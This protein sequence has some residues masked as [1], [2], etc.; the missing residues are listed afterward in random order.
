MSGHKIVALWFVLQIVL[1]FTAP[2]QTCDLRDLF[3]PQRHDHTSTPPESCSTPTLSE[4]RLDGGG[5][6]P[7][8]IRVSPVPA[9]Y[10]LLSTSSEVPMLAAQQALMR[11]G[12]DLF[13]T[14]PAQVLVLRI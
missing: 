6:C 11:L 13:P 9:P 8:N 7:A 5:E 3:G 1:P 10:L 14:P 2:L 4:S 12:R